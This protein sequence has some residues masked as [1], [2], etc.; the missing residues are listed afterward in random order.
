MAATLL[1]GALPGRLGADP[2]VAALLALFT[3]AVVYVTLWACV[4]S[5]HEPD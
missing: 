1:S 5:W 2:P 4:A 3:G